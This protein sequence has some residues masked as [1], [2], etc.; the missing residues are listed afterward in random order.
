MLIKMAWRNLW[1]RKRRTLITAFTVAFGVFLSVT[2]TGIGDYS[3]TNAINTSAKMGF[4]HITVEPIG[5]N[6]HPTLDKRL[7]DTKEILS[8]VNSIPG[9]SYAITRIMGQAMF[10]SAIKSV[11]GMFIAIDPKKESPER[12]F[13]LSALIEG[14]VFEDINGRGVIVGSEM[15]KKLN[16]RIGKK[17]V[18]TTTDVNGEIVSE[19]ARVTGIFQ[20]GVDEV[21][22]TMVLLPINRVR[23]TL[24]Y[25]PNEASFI[26]IFIK[27]QRYADR[28]RDI[29]AARIGN[30]NMEVLTWYET[31]PDLAS[32]IT[33]DKGT[34]YIFQF[35]V[36]LLIAAGILNTI[37][38]SV[39]ERK[40]E[41]GI[42]MAIG[43]APGRLI[44][45]VLS[46]TFCI[47]LVGLVMGVILTSP[48]YMYMKNIGIDFSSS[49]KGAS[50][51]MVPIETVIKLRLFK[52]SIIA[53]LT[54]VFALTMIAGLYPAIKAGRIPPVESLKNI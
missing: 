41:F 23:E 5:Y 40:R 46:E 28:M 51:A 47:G 6:D 11:G 36:G 20:T 42:M 27:D 43:M 15:A 31:Q 10:A 29:V 54:G 38:M 30:S 33:I 25:G 7:P 14:S 37:L 34:N 12:N 52:E 48:W 16:L 13:F 9:V 21:D 8:N 22:G 24:Q 50:F 18:Y 39:M 45:L 2:F 35:I 1:R 4:G 49:L 17:L 19:I 53:I 26:S 3:Y 44:K 32:M